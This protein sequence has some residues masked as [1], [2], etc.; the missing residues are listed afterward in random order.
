MNCFAPCLIG[1]HPLHCS[2]G[3]RLPSYFPSSL[4]FRVQ[5][6]RKR[7]GDIP[8]SFG[9]STDGWGACLSWLLIAASLVMI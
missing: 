4:A 2:I 7:F 6:Y 1:H 8:V 3:R 5:Q 9:G